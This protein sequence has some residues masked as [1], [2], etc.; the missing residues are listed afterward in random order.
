[1]PNER[2]RAPLSTGGCSANSL[3]AVHFAASHGESRRRVVTS[4]AQS[5]KGLGGIP[6]VRRAHLRRHHRDPEGDH[7]PQP[8]TVILTCYFTVC[9]LAVSDVMLGRLLELAVSGESMAGS[10]E[11]WYLFA[12]GR[13]ELRALR[14]G[15]QDASLCFC[16][17]VLPIHAPTVA[18]FA[19]ASSAARYWARFRS[20]SAILATISASSLAWVVSACWAAARNRSV[21]VIPGRIRVPAARRRGQ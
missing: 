20:Y 19:P 10:G 18:G 17:S 12:D 8:R 5:P 3:K 1:M 4:S 7:R 14:S 15:G 9:M 13:E 2:L 6:S 21:S 11:P 16:A